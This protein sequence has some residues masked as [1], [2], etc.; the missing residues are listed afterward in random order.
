[1][2]KKRCCVETFFVRLAGATYSS[3]ITDELK[4]GEGIVCPGQFKS[5]F[6]G[7]RRRIGHDMEEKIEARIARGEEGG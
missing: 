6:Q 1:M 5:L 2:E 3:E 7:L 4:G